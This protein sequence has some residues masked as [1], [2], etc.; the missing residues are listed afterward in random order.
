MKYHEFTAM[1]TTILLAADGDA[2][3]IMEG[4]ARVEELVRQYEQRFTRFTDTS[5][6]ARLNQSA[7]KWF[8]ASPEMVE[9][10]T[11]ALRYHQDTGGLYDPAILPAL[12]Q[13]GYNRS[14]DAIRAAGSIVPPAKKHPAAASAGEASF[15]QVRLDS[16]TNSIRVPEGVRIDLG[17]IAKGWIAERAAQALTRYAKACVVDAGGDIF[18]CGRPE[19]GQ[20]WTVSLEDPF[21]V[22]RDLA[23]LTIDPGAVATSTTMKRRWSQAGQERHHLIDP[24]TGEPAKSPWVSVTVIADH[25]AKAEVVA[26]ALL[27]G[28]PKSA[29]SIMRRF[30]YAMYIGVDRERRLWGSEKARKVMVEYDAEI[31]PG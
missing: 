20:G 27:I 13:A 29:E 22:T 23:V 26:K 5:E 21:D 31:V 8:H 6:L 17:G 10:I 14:M 3:K 24:R 25:A 11:L 18:A 7:G 9:V 12:E 28:G 16:Y 30:P 15:H 1:N 2:R 4:F 19:N